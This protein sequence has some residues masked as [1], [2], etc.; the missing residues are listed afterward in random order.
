[1]Q[2]SI[3]A[4]PLLQRALLIEHCYVIG[5]TNYKKLH[6]ALVMQKSIVPLQIE[7]SF[8]QL[9]A[10]SNQCRSNE[11]RIPHWL[12]IILLNVFGGKHDQ[13]TGDRE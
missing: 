13:A 10:L 3:A 12:P 2:H 6:Q 1:M 7:L 8:V 11:G 5:E 4:L 9:K